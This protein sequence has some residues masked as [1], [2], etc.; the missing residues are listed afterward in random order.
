MWELVTME[1]PWANVHPLR[2]VT[3]VAHEKKTLTIP[4]KCPESIKSLMTA[5]WNLK[6]QER[7]S[8]EDI[9]HNL[10]TIQDIS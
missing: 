10:S 1:A 5:C 6:P 2:V 3:M 9:L 4:P 7:P 8:F